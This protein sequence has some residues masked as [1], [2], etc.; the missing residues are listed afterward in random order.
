MIIYEG[1]LH[2]KK[3]ERYLNQGPR[4]SRFPLI[5]TYGHTELTNHPYMCVNTK[6]P[7]ISDSFLDPFVFVMGRFKAFLQEVNQIAS[8]NFPLTLI[9][10]THIRT[11]LD[12]GRGGVALRAPPPPSRK[13]ETIDR[14]IMVHVHFKRKLLFLVMAVRPFLNR[15]LA[16]SR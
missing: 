2:K 8:C 14:D 9:D 6:K 3:L 15:F 11:L 13:L 10:R 4:K 7:T 5:L 16:D 12:R 1:N